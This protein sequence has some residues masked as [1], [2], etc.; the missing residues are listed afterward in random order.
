VT[1]AA[2]G[3]T[4]NLAIVFGAAVVFPQG[5]SGG[6]DWFAVALSVAAFLA[7]YKYKVDVLWVVIAVGLIGLGWTLLSRRV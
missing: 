3:V 2:V 1:V 6:T 4:L 7:L 5:I